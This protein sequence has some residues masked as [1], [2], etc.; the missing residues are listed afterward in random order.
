MNTYTD[1]TRTWNNRYYADLNKPCGYYD[2]STLS[3][4]INVPDEDKLFALTDDQ[5]SSRMTGN[6]MKCMAVIN[7]EWTEY[8]PPISPL[9]LKDQATSALSFARTTVYNNYGIL[10]EDTPEDW[11]TYIKALM[12]ISNG[13]DTTSTTLPTQPTD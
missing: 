9:S 10:N 7:G 3:T 12:L 1:G 5:W 13:K 11:V 4:L 6:Q 8:K 2:V